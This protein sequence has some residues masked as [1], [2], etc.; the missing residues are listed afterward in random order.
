[1]KESFPWF[2]FRL[3]H[4]NRFIKKYIYINF[5]KETYFRVDY[6]NAYHSENIANFL[7]VNNFHT[8]NLL[9][10]A[11]DILTKMFFNLTN[12]Y[13]YVISTVWKDIITNKIY[14]KNNLINIPVY[15]IKYAPV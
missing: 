7:G 10:I 6:K 13:F 11:Q 1:M 14:I 2:D 9:C 15:S 4:Y 3:L 8:P 12:A 5:I